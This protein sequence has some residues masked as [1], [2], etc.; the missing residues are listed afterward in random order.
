MIKL[1]F[2]NN[3]LISIGK[4]AG[5]E[6]QKSRYCKSFEILNWSRNKS[7]DDQYLSNSQVVRNLVMPGTKYRLQNATENVH[8]NINDKKVF[9]Q[10]LFDWN[11][12]HTFVKLQRC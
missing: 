2:V 5:Y 4:S 7:G 6:K 1:I 12:F 8:K 11:F 3:V 9:L 10:I